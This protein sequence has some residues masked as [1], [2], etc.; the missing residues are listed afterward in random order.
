MNLTPKLKIWIFI[1]VLILATSGIAAALIGNSEKIAKTPEIV[2]IKDIDFLK[3]DSSQVS[4]TV[5]MVVNNPN[6]INMTLVGIDAFLLVENE[7]IGVVTDNRR[8]TLN[9]DNLNTITVD[10]IIDMPKSSDIFPALLHK[11]DVT[12]E[13]SGKLKVDAIVKDITFN[14]RTEKKISF[15]DLVNKVVKRS[16]SHNGIELEKITP[17]SVG[18]FSTSLYLETIMRN[19]F[20]IEY[21][22]ESVSCDLFLPNKNKSFGYWKYKGSK[23]ALKPNSIERLNGEITLSNENFIENMTTTIFG[24]KKITA[25]C[26]ADVNVADYSFNVPFEKTTRIE[27]VVGF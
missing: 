23:L 22:I 6:R 5:T 8:H 11:D 20:G 9:S 25:K 24:E 2:A 12:F 19:D 17:R 27:S 16:I 13:I 3:V 18:I 7:Q 10:G 15:R 14:R 1:V 26:S 4:F 21:V